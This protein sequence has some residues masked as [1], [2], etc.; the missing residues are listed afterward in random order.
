MIKL[1][2]E[3]YL[4]EMATIYKSVEYGIGVSVN[5]DSNR[6]GNPYFKFYNNPNYTKATKIIRILFASP[7][8][9]YHKDGKQL[10]ELNNKEKKLLID[11]LRQESNQ[12]D[13]YTNWEIAKYNWNC[14]YLEVQLNMKKYFKGEYDEQYTS[15]AGYVPSTLKMPDYS[16]LTI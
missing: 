12:Y 5:P 13:G 3:E 6:Q 14:E 8:Y 10:W 1:V 4:D 11:I 15:N 7:D 9:V 2:L 16:K